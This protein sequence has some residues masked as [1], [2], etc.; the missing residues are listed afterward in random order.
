MGDSSMPEIEDNVADSM[1]TGAVIGVRH[2]TSL[3][4]DRA[5]RR[6]SLV[7][8]GHSNKEKVNDKNPTQVKLFSQLARFEDQLSLED[9]QSLKEQWDAC[10][11][12][13]NSE[14]FRKAFTKQL[15]DKLGPDFQDRVTYL[16][17]KMDTNHDAVVDWH[18]FCTYVLL[19]LQE[20]DA[21]S[22]ERETPLQVCYD[23]MYTGCADPI[24]RIQVLTSPTRFVTV[25]EN[26]QT[27]FYDA[28]MRVS[29]V[30][31]LS[32]RGSGTLKAAAKTAGKTTIKVTDAMFMVNSWRIV[33]ATSARELQ[34]FHATAGRLMNTVLMPHVASCID[35]YYNPEDTN[36]AI[37]CFG[38]LKGNVG[39]IYFRKA[40]QQLFDAMTT[41]RP[42]RAVNLTD[43]PATDVELTG[44]PPMTTCD[45]RLA[46]IAKPNDDVLTEAVK[47]VRYAPAMQAVIS[48]AGT[49]DTALC[50]TDLSHGTTRGRVRN[51]FMPKACVH[52]DYSDELNLVCT[53]GVDAIVRLWNPYITSRPLAVFRGHRDPIVR[54]ALNPT[55]KQAIS[56]SSSEVIKI[57]DVVERVCLNTLIDIFPHPEFWVRI[58]ISA[59]VWHDMS[60]S[61]IVTCSKELTILQ[62]HRD[63]DL[64]ITN[65][66]HECEV[67][68]VEFL[69]DIDV[70]CT[71]DTN[72]TIVTWKLS[73]GEKL[74]E[75]KHAHFQAAVTYLAAHHHGR[76]L[77]SGASNGEIVVWNVQAGIVLQHMVK[78]NP[79]EV[80]GILSLHDKVMSVGHDG[81]VVRFLDHEDVDVSKAPIKVLQDRSY[82]TDRSHNSD[83]TCSASC[84]DSLM[85]SGSVDGEILIWNLRV[86]MAVKSLSAV[87]FRVQWRSASVKAKRHWP[88]GNFFPDV[89]ASASKN[90][91]AVVWLKERI[92]AASSG[93][94]ECATLVVAC[95]GGCVA[96]W[97][98]L[99]GDMLGAFYVVPSNA[100]QESVHGLAV[101]SANEML[102]TGDSMGNAR[103]YNIKDYCFKGFDDQPPKVMAAW[104][105]HTKLITDL[106]YVET[107]GVLV[108]ASY[109]R[110]VRVWN[111]L[112]GGDMGGYVG[113]FGAA[114]GWSLTAHFPLHKGAAA[115]AEDKPRHGSTTS[116]GDHGDHH[117]DGHEQH[118]DEKHKAQPAAK[119]QMPRLRRDT[120]KASEAVS[121][122]MHEQALNDAED[123]RR[124]RSESESSAA[125]GSASPS[126]TQGG[127]QS[128][129]VNATTSRTSSPQRRRSSLVQQGSPSLDTV[130]EPAQGKKSIKVTQGQEGGDE[131]DD[132]GERSDG[133]DVFDSDDSEGEEEFTHMIEEAAKK[134]KAEQEAI[135][136]EANRVTN[137]AKQRRAKE[138]NR[139]GALGGMYSAGMMERHTNRM[140]LHKEAGKQPTAT[141]AAIPR[142]P[143]I[144]APFRALSLRHARLDTLNP[145][146]VPS[147]VMRS[148]RATSLDHMDTPESTTA[149]T[150]AG[151]SGGGKSGKKPATLRL[152][153]GDEERG[154][155]SPDK[156][157]TA[158][159]PKI[160]KPPKSPKNVN[161][162][163]PKSPRLPPIAGTMSS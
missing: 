121:Q 84:G 128:D 48:C 39:A 118:T 78:V 153:T 125:D 5:V 104:Q 152:G 92:K 86:G 36:E 93:N 54:V 62:L 101:D 23:S 132:G 64:M 19:G 31:Y 88:D 138:W 29:N 80:H 2:S 59:F 114:M 99:K 25:S 158:S 156:K 119:A 52:F 72:G 146:R 151:K 79:R 17:K 126:G 75:F 116:H 112:G 161:T 135:K 90:V 141:D 61:I 42:D 70:L 74:L 45:V 102:I 30:L 110:S 46:H 27:T 44:D 117:E 20:K 129:T 107:R 145:V 83:V 154:R 26:G 136:R 100:G 98:A 16:F 69:R 73:S 105:A 159:P 155:S 7:I 11:G 35:Y 134:D 76:R 127:A 122:H 111:V 113:C 9:M 13:L 34:F 82:T 143:N 18:E 77:L 120:D 139:V 85:A 147:A 150:T 55:F 22:V 37:L 148:R 160:M 49:S 67:S 15:G 58:P 131:M 163:P 12:A 81:T 56:M 33:L 97:N 133:D 41:W 21:L 115:I 4:N 96:F 94:R 109:D 8:S 142:L 149:G 50:I 103:I 1:Q 14:V 28:K 43:L 65:T 40:S 130:D 162:S 87:A 24:V 68:C 3:L 140:A 89:P 32:T 10:N 38:D 60:Q 157:T 63:T 124:H 95:D 106:V 71:G 123:S 51:C 137:S 66:T 53:G 144:C 108:T 47:L 91:D 6:N 57:W